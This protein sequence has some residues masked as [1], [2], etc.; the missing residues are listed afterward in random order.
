M[1][2]ET[3]IIPEHNPARGRTDRADMVR[4]DRRRRKS[5]TLNRM[6]QFKL[7][8]FDKDQLDL[9]NYVYRWVND[10][11]N[12][13][14]IAY[15]EDYDFVAT[16]KIKNFNAELTDSE[17]TERVRMLTGRDKNGNPVYSYLMQKPR[18]W[19]EAD[20]E[21]RVQFREDMMKGVVYNGEVDKLEGNASEGD[22]I[23]AASGNQLGGSAQ[24]RRGPISR[25]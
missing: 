24:R 21:E 2:E 7:D 14:R 13:M 6:A 8:I 5:G 20:Q 19:F 18:D 15:G 23:Y 12:R 16:D 9:E 17:S 4:A 10:E 22:M 3:T 25:K 11:D 1:S